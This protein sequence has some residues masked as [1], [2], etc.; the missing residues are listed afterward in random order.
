MEKFERV[1]DALREVKKLASDLEWYDEI[2]LVYNDYRELYFVTDDGDE[3][4]EEINKYWCDCGMDS[5]AESEAG[6]YKVWVYKLAENKEK[7]PNTYKRAKRSLLNT[8]QPLIR[9]G[10]D[11]GCEYSVDFVIN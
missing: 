11:I 9:T 10:T 6:N 4:T 2:F 8:D 1:T 5:T 7:Y 3:I